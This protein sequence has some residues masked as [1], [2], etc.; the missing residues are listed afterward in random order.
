MTTRPN[1]KG[2]GPTRAERRR[3]SQVR[4]GR[5]A[6]LVAL[7]ASALALV[8]WF[9]AG[10]LMHQRQ[11]LSS[12]ATR[13]AQ[14]SQQDRALAQEQ[15]RL[16][17]SAE[18]ARIARQQYQLVSPGQRAYQVL[19]ANGKSGSA[20]SQGDPGLQPLVVPS[21]SSELPRGRRSEGVEEAPRLPAAR[22]HRPRPA[23]WPDRGVHRRA[24]AATL[25]RAPEPV[26]APPGCLRAAGCRGLWARIVQTLEFWR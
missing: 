3:A 5:L 24:A 12:T 13:L 11:A 2:R 16:Q 4:R 21:A 1:G 25:L 22:T 17:S 20:A 9:P 18:V 7:C 26:A 15:R 6:L 8:A 10:A 14:L 23:P 19:P